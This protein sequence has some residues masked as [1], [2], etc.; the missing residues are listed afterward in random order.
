M[1]IHMDQ[2]KST[3]QKENKIPRRTFTTEVW[4]GFFVLIS[5][6]GAGYLSLGLG[7]MELASSKYYKVYAEFDNISG[8]NQGA[9]VEIAGVPIGSVENI[10]L[11]DAIA[12]V[13]L[14]IDKDIKIREDDIATI[15]TKGIIGD[16]FV[17]ISRGASDDYV[18]PGDTIFNT[19]SIV[20]FEDLIGKIIHSVT[21][22]DDDK[23]SDK[24]NSKGS[25]KDKK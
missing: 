7:G 4:V 25:N 15:R 22:G 23:G 18:K 12:I 6:I 3:K 17:K 24:D 2:S 19:E 5:L 1:G 16:R 10:S 13:E 9:S 21:S 11:D 8:L 20:D 14:K